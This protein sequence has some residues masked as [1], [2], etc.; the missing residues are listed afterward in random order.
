MAALV[1]SQR[2]GIAHG[3]NMRQASAPA[4]GRG[5][6]INIFQET[7]DDLLASL[8]HDEASTR[9]GLQ[10]TPSEVLALRHLLR[11]HIEE[12]EERRAS[13]EHFGPINL[14][15]AGDGPVVSSKVMSRSCGQRAKLNI[16]VV[17]L[18][19]EGP[20]SPQTCLGRRLNTLRFDGSKN[21]RCRR[22]CSHGLDSSSVKDVL[23]IFE[24]TDCGEKGC[25]NSVF[26]RLER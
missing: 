9:A 24:T 12:L 10:L 16:V 4:G 8:Q 11:P 7:I 22:A 21:F 13:T 5:E 20:P 25:A 3:H 23:T 1:P 2:G 26:Q 17:Q 14:M 19:D 6:R 18:S 15:A